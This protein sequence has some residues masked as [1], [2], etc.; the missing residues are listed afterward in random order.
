MS[1]RTLFAALA[2]GA[3]APG[4]A[5][6]QLPSWLGNTGVE[7]RAGASIGSHSASAAALDLVPKP[8]FDV[9]VK[10]EVIP[11]L[12]VFG[13][14]YMTAFGCEE[15]FCTERDLS[16]VG[17]HAALGAEWMPRLSQ[18]L[19]RPWVRGGFLFGTTE[20]GTEGE[21][22]SAGIGA[23]VGVGVEVALGRVL[24][25]PGVSYRYLTANTESSTAEAV[26]L[27]FHVGLGIRLGGG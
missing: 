13:G 12:S 27:S 5:A 6:G 4:S 20:A 9:V 25:L 24:V 10:S 16:I 11:A 22:P 23:D 26:A 17:N 21:P 7:I 18:L 2:V 1:P 14:Y 19:F 8:S 3:L 15:G